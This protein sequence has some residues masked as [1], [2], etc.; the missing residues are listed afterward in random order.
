LQIL[1]KVDA[2]VAAR[3]D[4]AFGHLEQLLDFFKG[5]VDL[6]HHGKRRTSSSPWRRSRG[7]RDLQDHATSV[8]RR[9]D[10]QMGVGTDAVE[11]PWLPP[12]SWR[13]C[14]I[15]QRPIGCVDR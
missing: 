1:E 11:R 6:C 14:R 13:L 5:F 15:E 12:L 4:Q 3:N 9:S 2:A 7:S 8:R 10:L